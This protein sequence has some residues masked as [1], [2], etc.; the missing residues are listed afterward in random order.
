MWGRGIMNKWL[1]ALSSLLVLLVLIVLALYIF[2]I[3]GI[4]QPHVSALPSKVDGL[5]LQV[6][7][8][9][10][11]DSDGL[12]S[13]EKLDAIALAL[14]DPTII[15]AMQ[16]AVAVNNSNPQPPDYDMPLAIVISNVTS[17]NSSELM[18]MD[19]GFLN[20]SSKTAYLYVS[21]KIAFSE[22]VNQ[23]IVYVDLTN[24]RT[25]GLLTF[26][27]LVSPFATITIPPGSIWYTQV[28]DLTGL[29]GG[30]EPAMQPYF[31]VNMDDVNTTS[32]VILSKNNFT[33]FKEGLP[34][35]ALKYVDFMTNAT[36]IADGNQPQHIA[37]IYD[38]VAT[39][40]ANVSFNNSIPPDANPEF[41]NYYYYV[42]IEN[43]D[44]D[45]EINI[46]YSYQG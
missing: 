12:T 17:E 40:T 5:T 21:F 13:A 30:Y 7:G 6:S 3:T 34:Y 42:L 9:D 29:A 35:T 11:K 22:L 14:N 2:P 37:S 33:K 38:G 32:M 18:G 4:L 16:Q 1:I 43:K 25:L 46:T 27:H 44:L 23:Y 24:N 45:K 39:C 10:Y 15:G 8:N 26:E 41:P 36:M 28:S 31:K 19:S 20:T